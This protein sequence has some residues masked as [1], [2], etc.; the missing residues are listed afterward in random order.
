MRKFPVRTQPLV[1]VPHDLWRCAM[2]PSAL[3]ATVSLARGCVRGEGGVETQVLQEVGMSARF[4]VSWLR[5][6]WQCLSPVLLSL[7]AMVLLGGCATSHPRGS[8]TSSSGLHSR[9][10]SFRAG[11]GTRQPEEVEGSAGGFF[12]QE[13]DPFQVVQEASGLEEEARHPAGA[14]LYTGQAR[15]LLG[16]LAKTRVTQRSF[17]PRRVLCWLLGEVLEGGER[18]EYA[19]LLRR[20]R[21]FGF[22]VL[23]RPDGYLV[24]ALT[25]EPIQRRG[26]VKLERGEWKAGS[27]VVGEFYFSL[28]GVL[29]PVNDV[30]RRV[31]TRP[32]AELG[33]EPDWLNAA[34]DGAQDALGELAMA[35]A[36][37]VL[38]P[39]CGVE[40][41]VQLPTT[42]ALLIASS[43]EY[44]ERYGAMSREDQI[45]EAARLAM[46]MLML[47]GRGQGA[48]GSVGRTGGLGA[49]LP[50][51]AVTAQ[52]VLEVRTVV[53][54]GGT[55][56]TT[57]GV[58]LGALSILHMASGSQGSTGGGS[59]RAGKASQA[60]ST[61]GPGRW[62]YKMPTTKSERALDYQEQVTGQPAWR[63]YMIDEV[64][65]DGFNGKE[66]LEAKGPN[67]K[68]FFEKDGTPQSWY[69]A[70]G[71]FT[72]LVEQAGKQSR[73]AERLR[74]PLI[75]HV[76][77]A[78]VAKILRKIFEKNRWTNITIHYTPPAP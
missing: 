8:P 7:V 28:G 70:S 55:M 63:V 77:D 37:S 67:Y 68:N 50:V 19:E 33:L 17:A 4:T 30:L 2:P 48:V 54:A 39:I 3:G 26:Q 62:T 32:W 21:R 61:Q 27:L 13:V 73:I 34:L 11:P 10:A 56:T 65:F 45:R 78:E 36:Q 51:L 44:F 16:R 22:L 76:A 14:A 1:P 5:A 52:G 15:Q 25:G 47:F 74:L 40:D 75:W 38:H 49:E 59:A 53:V 58:E 23:V 71:E 64:E 42:V 29:Y 6:T 46:H 20:T 12:E 41:L 43:P 72:E 66:L 18:V 24:G 57:L 60:A 31:D 69:V 35:L 9:P